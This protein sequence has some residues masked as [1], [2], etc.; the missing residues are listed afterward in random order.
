MTDTLEKSILQRFVHAGMSWQQFKLIQ[1]GFAD[2]PGLRLFYH[3]GEVEIVTVSPE[4]EMISCILAALLVEYFVEKNIEFTP[5]GSW[6]QEKEEEASVQADK[7]YCIGES[8]TTPDLSIEVVLTSGG[9]SKLNRYRSLA[10]PEVWFWEEG[11]LSLYR[12][13][14]EG[15]KRINRS[16]LLP[17]LDIELLTRCVLMAYTSRVAAIKEFKRAIASQT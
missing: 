5:T 9:P 11:L 8:S 2:S 14:S 12:L 10:V 15:Y 13:R 6:T 1:E 3:Q 7:S 16:E 17:D 4:H